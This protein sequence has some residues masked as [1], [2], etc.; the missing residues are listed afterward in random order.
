MVTRTDVSDNANMKCVFSQ[1]SG[2]LKVDIG[3]QHPQKR[4]A[5][6]A[7]GVGEWPQIPTMT[8]PKMIQK[9]TRL[10]VCDDTELAKINQK[11]KDE[12]LK[13]LAAS[14]ALKGSS[15]TGSA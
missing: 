8:N 3:C 15:A 13:L 14:K 10:A 4:S 12:K 2:D 5:D 9:H 7:F 1:I 6:V 11:M